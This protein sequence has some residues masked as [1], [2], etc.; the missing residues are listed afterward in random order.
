MQPTED[1]AYLSKKIA[2]LEVFVEREMPQRF[3]I[4]GK[5]LA[6]VAKKIEDISDLRGMVEKNQVEIARN[7]EF[8]INAKIESGK[9]RD[10]LRKEIKEVYPIITGIEYKFAPLRKQFDDQQ[11]LIQALNDKISNLAARLPTYDKIFIELA[12]I[13]ESI[14]FDAKRFEESLS[15]QIRTNF[16]TQENINRLEQDIIIL[17]NE[18]NEFRKIIGEYNNQF[19]KIN[20]IFDEKQKIIFDVRKELQS[21]IDSSSNEL[22][23]LVDSRVN[24]IKIPTIDHLANIDMVNKLSVKFDKFILDIDNANLRSLNC[25]SQILQINKTLENIRLLL[26][27]SELEK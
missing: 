2:A 19:I 26:K 21:L 25:D 12:N 23:H 24:N 15:K 10:V 6:E 17:R 22:K 27:K 3:N 18:N 13:K 8:A 11:A 20:S 4:F 14:S 5:R 9:D 1:F 16:E 7:A